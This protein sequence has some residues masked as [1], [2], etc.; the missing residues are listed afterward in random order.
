M[1]QH[2]KGRLVADMNVPTALIP[3]HII[4]TAYE[5]HRPIASLWVGGGTKG[6]PEQ[7]ANARRI[8]ACWNACEGID[9]EAVPGMVEA[10]KRVL[11][12]E[13]WAKTSDRMSS[14][15]IAD[16]LRAALAKATK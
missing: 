9:P 3:G 4:K 12:A 14:V 16:L 5:P 11:R 10:C 8:V 15:E 7:E 1:S 13:E 2:T 6:K